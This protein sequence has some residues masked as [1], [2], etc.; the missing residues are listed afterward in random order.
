MPISSLNELVTTLTTRFAKAKRWVN[1]SLG[2]TKEELLQSMIDVATFSTAYGAPLRSNSTVN[3][4]PFLGTSTQLNDSKLSHFGGLGGG[5]RLDGAWQLSANGI[6]KHE[7]FQ[8]TA[9]ASNRY[10]TT[11]ALPKGSYGAV[12]L[13]VKVVALGQSSGIIRKVYTFDAST[14][15][16]ASNTVQ[17][18]QGDIATKIFVGDPDWSGSNIIVPLYERSAVNTAK[19]YVV[20]VSISA[21]TTFLAQLLTQT[22]LL[23][24]VATTTRNAASQNVGLTSGTQ[25]SITSDANGLR[26]IND[27]STPNAFQLYGTNSAGTRGWYDQVA[28]KSVVLKA[29]R[30]RQ[31]TSYTLALADA[32][33]I[34][35]Q[36]VATAN[37][38]TI[39]PNSSVA[40]E[41]DTACTVIQLGAGQVTIVAGAGVTLR[42][43]DGKLKL[44]VQYS[45]CTMIQRA[46]NDWYV[47]GDTTS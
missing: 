10:E 44:R 26:L 1:G 32:W 16:G 9:H 14:A 2:I 18:A 29:N 30:N 19:I 12:T 46:I 24:A 40:F 36:D 15:T 25:M 39:P 42:T 34:V 4:I 20:E 31:T 21:N 22:T 37:T 28:L 35:E 41:I 11:I 13:E 43:A 23:S 5:V 45:S 27:V 17:T 7:L 33:G 3:V 38:V 47:I 8:P 6:T